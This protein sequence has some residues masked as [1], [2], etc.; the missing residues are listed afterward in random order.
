MLSK[1]I[2]I[3]IK[4]SL[5]FIYRNNTND[6]R[7]YKVIIKA[8]KI[9]ILFKYN[10]LALF[11]FNKLLELQGYYYLKKKNIIELV[12]LLRISSNF[13]MVYIKDTFKKYVK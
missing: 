10:M 2:T 9:G 1:E 6:Y 12:K 5:D 8:N 3:S 7:T 11:Y 13:K 4:N